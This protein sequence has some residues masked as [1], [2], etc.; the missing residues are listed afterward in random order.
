MKLKSNLFNIENIIRLR[1][2]KVMWFVDKK[3]NN[4]WLL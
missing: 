3:F 4:F 2:I 1:K